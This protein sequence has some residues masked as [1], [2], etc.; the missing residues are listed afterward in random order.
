[1]T[2]RPPNPKGPFMTRPEVVVF[3]VNETLSDMSSMADRFE[4][5]GAP[6]HLARTWFAGVLRDGF[7][8]TAAGGNAGFATIA[9]DGLQ[10]L[11]SGT[12]TKVPVGPAIAHIMRGFADLDVHPDVVDGVHALKALDFRLATL[13]NGSTS[14]ADKLLTTAG[15]R[16]HFDS[17]LSVE[18]AGAWKPAP[19]AYQYAASVCGTDLGATMLVAVHPWDIDGAGRAGMPTAWLNRVGAPYPRCFRPPTL[20]VAALP[21]LAQ[22]LR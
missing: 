17:V 1:V 5:V 16:D 4:D 13:S 14:V 20:T 22:S 10:T 7:A 3:D 15:L 12:P 19:A 9:A 11:L 8:L 6:G 21:E 2:Y 18:N